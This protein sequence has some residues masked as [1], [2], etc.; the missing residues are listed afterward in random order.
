MEMKG[1][2]N[3]GAQRKAERT[4]DLNPL[5]NREGEILVETQQNERAD[6]Q[7]K[8]PGGRPKDGRHGNRN[9]KDRRDQKK[10]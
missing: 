8:H 9:E 5:V 2:R 3:Q 6:I 7:A 10:I 4:V 1:E